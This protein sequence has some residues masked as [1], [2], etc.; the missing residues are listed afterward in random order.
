LHAILDRIGTSVNHA[1]MVL[2]AHMHQHTYEKRARLG[3][4]QR[5]ELNG[6]TMLWGRIDRLIPAYLR[7]E[8]G[9]VTDREIDAVLDASGFAYGDQWGP[10]PTM[11]AAA[12]FNFWKKQGKKIILLPQA[13]GPF[14]SRQI[15][16][17]FHMIA[18]S[19]DL[20]Y[21]RDRISYK[22]VVDLVGE[23]PNLKIA[24]DFTNLLASEPPPAFD[25]A[26]KRFAIVPNFRMIHK[27]SEADSRRY[28]PFLAMCGWHLVD[29]GFHPL[30]LIHGERED[31]NLGRHLA[32]VIGS[33]A[34]V[35]AETDPLRIKGMLGACEGVISSRY[36]GL[37]SALSQ[38]V[39]SLATGWSH[40]YEALME[41]Y[42]FPEGLIP[43]TAEDDL[44][45][46][47]IDFILDAE[48]RTGLCEKIKKASERQKDLA[49][50]M[51]EQILAV[52]TGSG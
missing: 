15:K 47:R 24:P 32:R 31:L 51:W 23:R 1:S 49:N 42:E 22:H 48:T 46:D 7:R 45:R 2:S 33:D 13:F 36:H 37:V 26:G 9:I 30:V 29:K 4:Y 39:P 5:I 28:M 19:A 27:T 21:A 52:I 18:D 20:I 6:P 40:K 3:L 11:A 41:D 43:V 34:D 17:A 25:P 14:T 16:R 50:R 10:G 35:I 12:R 38:G 44:I 8:Y